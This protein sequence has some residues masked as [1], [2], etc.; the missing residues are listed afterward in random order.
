MTNCTIANNVNAGG[1][2]VSGIGIYATGVNLAIVDCLFSNN[3]KGPNYYPTKGGGIYFESG[4]LSV[5]N[6]IFVANHCCSDR[7]TVIGGGASVYLALAASATINNCIF[8]GNTNKNVLSDGGTIYLAVGSSKTVT[9][10]NCT[11]VANTPGKYGGAFYV[12]SGNLIVKNSILWTNTVTTLG[13][14]IFA[15][16]AASVVNV[17][18]SLITNT[19]A[20]Y[21]LAVVGASVNFGDGMIVGEDPLFASAT[22]LHLKSKAGRWNPDTQAWVRDSVSS[23]AISTGDPSDT[24]WQYEPYPNGKRINMGAYGGTPYASKYYT[25]PGSLF[26]V[27]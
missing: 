23:P 19:A 2:N 14:E 27:Q 3:I 15:T 4:A 24:G 10:E 12:T 26:M 9:V 6:S 16:N 22:D 7:A 8:Q 20:P 25:I 5:R 17:S 13:H 21:V 11:F 1:Y 18:Y